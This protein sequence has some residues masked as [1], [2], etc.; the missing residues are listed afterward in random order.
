[1]KISKIPLFAWYHTVLSFTDSK[2]RAI[3]YNII[4][5]PNERTAP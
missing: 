4:K 3:F 5:T 1:M 2:F